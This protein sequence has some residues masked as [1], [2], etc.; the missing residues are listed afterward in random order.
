MMYEILFSVFGVTF[1]YSRQPDDIQLP[2]SIPDLAS[3]QDY[4]YR[5]LPKSNSIETQST[6]ST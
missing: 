2:A 5:N 6:I 4:D 3:Y 1:D